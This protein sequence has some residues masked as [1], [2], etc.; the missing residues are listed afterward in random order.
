MRILEQTRP[1][2][3]PIPGIDHAT[4]AGHEQGLQQLS[5]WRQTLA[6]GAVT[7]P[8][9]HDC[10]EVLLCQGGL[11]EVHQDGQVLRFGAE[12]T[13]VLPRGHLHQIFNV[14]TQPLELVGIFAAT[15]V[16]AYL[17]DD[18]VLPLP[19]TS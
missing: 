5:I 14:G 17:P 16:A 2:P 4:W 3:S 7:P 18:S 15:P 19:W 10:D 1:Q 11:G 12:S 13:V 8:H 6:P 9:R